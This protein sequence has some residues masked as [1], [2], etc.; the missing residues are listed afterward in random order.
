MNK[1][2]LIGNLTRDPELTETSAGTKVCRFTLA[3]GREYTQN[4][5]RPTD[6]FDC[7]AWR[8]MGENIARYAHKGE[9]LAVEG[10][11]ELNSYEDRDGNKRIRT[12]IQVHRAEFLAP[13]RAEEDQGEGGAKK[14]ALIPMDD[15]GDI[16][17]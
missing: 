7:T 16:P 3:V 17:F 11:V 14:P 13:R 4:G 8:N 10:A 6:F 5:A 12:N 9:K 2:F 15:G 1:I